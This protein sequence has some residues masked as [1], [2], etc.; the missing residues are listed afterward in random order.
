MPAPPTAMPPARCSRNQVLPLLL[1][2]GW[3]VCRSEVRS[4]DKTSF[5]WLAIK[6][7]PVSNSTNKKWDEQSK[8]LSALEHIPNAAEMSWFITTYFEVRGIRLFESVY[9][10]TSSLDSGGFSVHVGHFDSMGL[11]RQLLLGRQP[12]RQPWGLGQQEAVNLEPLRACP[13]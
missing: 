1:E 8:L 7:T 9:V 13:S 6:K 4:R 3:V 2:N 11:P 12:Q 10:R 5:G